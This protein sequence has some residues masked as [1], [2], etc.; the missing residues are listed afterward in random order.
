MLGGSWVISPLIW[1]IIRVTLPITPLMT[2]HEPPSRRLWSAPRASRTWRH[3]RGDV[4][5]L[6]IQAPTL[7]QLGDSILSI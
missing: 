2:T 3:H 7:Q 1:V 5:V 6:V 4:F